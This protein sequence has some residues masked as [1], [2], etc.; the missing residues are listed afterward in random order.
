M[1]IS[2]GEADGDHATVLVDSDIEAGDREGYYLALEAEEAA[3]VVYSRS[4]AQQPSF[5]RLPSP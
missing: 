5:S 3:K 1:V 2:L 4:R